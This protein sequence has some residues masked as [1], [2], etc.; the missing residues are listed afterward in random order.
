MEAYR[1]KNSIKRRIGI[2]MVLFAV[3]LG[4]CNIFIIKYKNKLILSNLEEYSQHQMILLEREIAFNFDI[5]E[6]VADTI[7]DT[8]HLENYIDRL[9][10]IAKTNSYWRMGIANINGDG[11]LDNGQ[12]LNIAKRQYF[13]ESIQ[14][15]NYLSSVYKDQFWNIKI[16]TY[17]VP[18][19]NEEKEV[20]VMSR[21]RVSLHLR[22]CHIGTKTEQLSGRK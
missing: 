21:G 19:F 2:L 16:N 4:G 10:Q 17:S 12:K 14:G 5:L 9:N 20:A 15:K 6:Q 8:K 7:T 18:I 22:W 3:L 13:K 1:R 11:Y